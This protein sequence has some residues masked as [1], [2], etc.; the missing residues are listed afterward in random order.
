MPNLTSDQAFKVAQ[1][2][3]DLSAAVDDFRFA[4]PDLPEPRQDQLRDSADSL[5]AASD[6]FADI[7]INVA[8]DNVQGALDGLGQIT[9][10]INN[11]LTKL[12][13]LNKAFQI[14]GVLVE[15]GTACATANPGGIITAISDT[16]NA[17]Q[18]ADPSK[19]ASATGDN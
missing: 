16:V 14:I 19:Q 18:G 3:S 6:K 17:L 9:G 11:D 8:L 2:L 4:H 15:L 7:G 12:A 1:A 5:R 13:D 10:K